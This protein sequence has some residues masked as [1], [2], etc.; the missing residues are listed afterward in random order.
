MRRTMPRR[1]TCVWPMRPWR[2]PP[3]APRPTSTSPAS[4]PSPRRRCDAVHPGYG[5]LSER[6]DFAQACAEAGLRFIGP[7]PEQLALFGDKARARA[8][9][10]QCDVPVMPGSP[11]RG[12]AG[13]GAGLLR[14][15]AGRWRG[16]HGQGHRRRR[17]PRHAGGA[18]RRR[19]ARGPCALHVGSQGAFGVEGVYVERLMRNARHIEIQVLGD[20]RRREPG[21]ARVHAAAALPEAG[22]DRAQPFA[23]RGAA[24]ASHAGRAAH[25]AGR[26]LPGPGHLRIPGRRAFD[27]AALRLHRGQPAPAGRAH[28]DRGGDRAGPGATADRRRGGPAAR[29]A[30]IGARCAAQRGFA[31]QWRINAETLD[32]QGNARPSGGTL[33]RFDLPAGPGVRVDTHGYA[34]ARA[35]A[36]LRHAAGQADRPL[37]PRRAS[38]MRCGA[39]CA[40]WTNAASRASRPTW[41][42]CA[43]SPQ[44]PSSPAQA[45]HTRF[46]EAHLADL[47]PQPA[48]RAAAARPRACG[49]SG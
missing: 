17:R 4:S 33:S 18:G 20:G 22:G 10:K 21:R 3:P 26:G 49:R 32:A 34:G 28:G 2:S 11:G 39:R 30:R 1:C 5:F 47:L 8:L 24:R 31:V 25:G 36:A 46:V 6:A 19:T 16:R 37:A 12:H 48:H 43:P 7:T 42:C 45:V 14:R 35:L 44:G 29:W 15:A 41:R 38:P 40:R 23:L 13:R 9:A 27:R